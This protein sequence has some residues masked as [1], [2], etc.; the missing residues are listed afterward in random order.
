MP[1]II[2]LLIAG[3]RQLLVAFFVY[4]IANLPKIIGNLLAA[5]GFYFVV[6]KPMASFGMSFI[7]ARFNGAPGTVLETLY[8]LNIDDYVQIVFAAIAARKTMDAGR[9]ALKSRSTT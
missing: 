6:A 9:I 2:G 1:A 7:L 3:L 5:L 8:Y 4:V